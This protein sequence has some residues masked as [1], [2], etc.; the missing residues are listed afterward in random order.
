M[1]KSYTGVVRVKREREKKELGGGDAGMNEAILV[2]SLSE[3]KHQL[4]NTETQHV[5]IIL[6]LLILVQ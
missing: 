2:C 3:M 1:K 6:L 4:K 5:M